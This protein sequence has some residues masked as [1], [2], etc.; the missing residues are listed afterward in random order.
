[1][2]DVIERL[3]KSDVSAYEI[4]KQT[5]VHASVIQRLRT[6]K[7]SIDESKYSNIEKLSQYQIK[8]EMRIELNHERYSMYRQEVVSINNSNDSEVK[9]GKLK[10]LNGN[11]VMALKSVLDSIGV[12]KN[13]EKEQDIL[14]FKM[15]EL[16]NLKE[17]IKARPINEKNTLYTH[18]AEPRYFCIETSSIDNEDNRSNASSIINGVNIIS[19]TVDFAGIN[20]RYKIYT[21][22]NIDDIEEAVRNYVTNDLIN[23][24]F[25][26]QQIIDRCSKEFKFIEQ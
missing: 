16:L 25:V 14:L 15:L 8:K 4:S 6:G 1:M 2:R 19:K 9:L 10:R 12:S 24:R 13:S 18:N 21:S 7:Q 23:S 5:G 26:A 17:G 20:Y 3:L 22:D 11:I